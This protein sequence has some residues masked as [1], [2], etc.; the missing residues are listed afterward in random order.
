LNFIDKQKFN[1]K[2]N[3][4]G[5]GGFN[6]NATGYLA[7]QNEASGFINSQLSPPDDKKRGGSRNSTLRPV[8]VKSLLEAVQPMPDAPAILDGQDLKYQLDSQ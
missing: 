1:K 3:M 8:T 4:M 2:R 6:Q 5:Y 7:P